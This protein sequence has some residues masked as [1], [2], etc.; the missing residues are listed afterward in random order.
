MPPDHRRS[1]RLQRTFIRT[2][3]HQ[4]LDLPQ[5]L[6]EN[7]GHL[8]RIGPKV[9]EIHFCYYSRKTYKS[10]LQTSGVW[11]QTRSISCAQLEYVF[12]TCIYV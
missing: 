9:F 3:L 1:Y 11:K 10:A 5:N 4:I 12:L 8:Q 7:V 6:A 2:P